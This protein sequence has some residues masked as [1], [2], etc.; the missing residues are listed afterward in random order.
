MGAG[1]ALRRT[2]PHPPLRPRSPLHPNVGRLIST[3]VLGARDCEQNRML[4]VRA[5]APRI[6]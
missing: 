2:R 5:K 3:H 4:N 6:I 1:A